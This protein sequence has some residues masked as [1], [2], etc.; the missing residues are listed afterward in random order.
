MLTRLFALALAVRAAQNSPTP[1]ADPSSA[2]TSAETAAA[3]DAG[4]VG[5]IVGETWTAIVAFLNLMGPRHPRTLI[6]ANNLCGSLPNS[7][8]MDFAREQA[9]IAEEV[10]GIGHWHTLLF[11]RRLADFLATQSS[12]T[13]N[14]A[15]EAMKI[16]EEACQGTVRLLG[17]QHRDSI[18]AEETA[19]V[20]R[21]NLV[22]TLDR[23]EFSPEALDALAAKA[24]AW[25]ARV[26][27]NAALRRENAVLRHENA[28]LRTASPAC[29]TP[30]SELPTDSDG[31][32]LD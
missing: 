29:V 30:T 32:E 23:L 5:A 2:P 27:E 20:S 11:R 18:A 13:L 28:S 21:A 15:I 1:H 10:H 24:P 7:E 17:T 14:D 31:S 16:S 12:C 9:K 6:A 19:G 8:V 26:A 25:D 22:S 4:A 3:L